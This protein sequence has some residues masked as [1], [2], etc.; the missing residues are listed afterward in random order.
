MQIMELTRSN[1]SPAHSSERSYH[2]HGQKQKLHCTSLPLMLAAGAATWDSSHQARSSDQATAAGPSVV[3]LSFMGSISN[4]LGVPS[5]S[6]TSTS[7]L[8]VT[9]NRR[10]RARRIRMPPF[11]PPRVFTHQEL[12]FIIGMVQTIR[13]AHAS[14]KPET[15]PIIAATGIPGHYSKQF[16][17]LSTFH[18]GSSSA[19]TIFSSSIKIRPLSFH[20]NARE[21]QLLKS[22]A[23]H[24]QIY[25]HTPLTLKLTSEVAVTL[26]TTYATKAFRD[27]L[28]SR[29]TFSKQRTR[30]VSTTNVMPA[31]A[32][33]AVAPATTNG[34]NAFWML[35]VG[36]GATAAS[37]TVPEAQ[38]W[39]FPAHYSGGGRGN[40]VQLGSMI[41][42]QQQAG[43]QQLGLGVTETNM[44][45]LGSGM[46]V[47]S[48]NN[49]VGLKMNLE[50]QH[51]H[52]NQTQGSDSGDENPATDSQ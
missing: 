6:P 26:T 52:E 21:R 45:L 15:L 8:T 24:H 43:G 7:S 1:K 32:M 29:K 23:F 35:P 30:F 39:T 36:G 4:Q 41:L 19:S 48:N 20:N 46:N 12:A 34:G 31:P 38:M 14:N 37:A 13:V 10:C 3:M 33:W 11:A 16:L 44:G 2:H 18:F 49:R 42:Q 5:S 51:H 25:P 40:P 50:Q 22:R 47:Y 28:F 9:P 17:P 27:E